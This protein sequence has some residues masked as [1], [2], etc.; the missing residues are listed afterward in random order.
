MDGNLVSHHKL[1]RRLQ[2]GGTVR[3]INHAG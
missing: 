1:F 2:E 3:Q